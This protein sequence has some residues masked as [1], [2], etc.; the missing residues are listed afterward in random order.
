M[1]LS[2]PCRQRTLSK[3]VAFRSLCD[4]FIEYLTKQSPVILLFLK[5][6]LLDVGIRRRRDMPVGSGIEILVIFSQDQLC[7]VEDKIAVLFHEYLHIST[8]WVIAG[9]KEEYGGLAAVTATQRHISLLEP[10]GKG[11]WELR[12]LK[13]R[14]VVWR[15]HIIGSLSDHWAKRAQSPPAP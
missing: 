9:P 14:W 7:L 12:K 5:T 8:F 13:K 3:G 6:R 1:P 4:K 10:Y 15:S 2:I 11:F